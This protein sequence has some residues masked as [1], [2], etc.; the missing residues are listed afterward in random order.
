V[1]HVHPVSNGRSRG[2]SN[3]TRHR[4]AAVFQYP[5]G[6]EVVFVCSPD[7]LTGADGLLGGRLVKEHE[8]LWA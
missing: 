8:G 2:V 4:E 7:D 6:L 1:A 3:C 5:R